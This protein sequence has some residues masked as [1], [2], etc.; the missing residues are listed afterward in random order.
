M[1]P[2]M[3]AR[4]INAE[5]AAR[6]RVMAQAVDWHEAKTKFQKQLPIKA[7]T[8]CTKAFQVFDVAP[9]ATAQSEAG[10]VKS[11]LG[12]FAYAN[13]ILPRAAP[14]SLFQGHN[15]GEVF[16]DG[17]VTMPVL[18]NREPTG[19]LSVWMSFTPAEIMSQRAGL[20]LAKGKVLIGGL[21][22]GWLLRRVAE[23][24]SVREIV[25]V[26]KSKELLDWYGRDLCGKI[27]METNKPIRVICDDV[28]NQ[29]GKH[30]EETRH[31]IDIWPDW[32]NYLSH[33][34]KEWREAIK[35]VKHFWGWGVLSLPERTGRW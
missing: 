30:G 32:P 26:E 12:N 6:E 7:A 24:K 11:P 8:F 23:K 15:T 31:L 29:M 16:F 19:R 2:V 20:K 13:R 21:G 28:L 22:I 25:L 17:P 14:L 10:T 34:P 5:K 35:A 4:F 1:T 9:S 3:Q 27:A 33:L 18:Y